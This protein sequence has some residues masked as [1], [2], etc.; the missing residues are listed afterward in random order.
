MLYDV[1]SLKKKIL[2]LYDSGEF[3]YSF[4]EDDSL[5][6]LSIKLKTPSQKSLITNIA[7][8]FDEIKKLES[9]ELHIE[10]REFSFKSLG[11]QK[12]PISVAIESEEIF[13]KFLGKRREFD[14]YKSAYLYALSKFSSL[15]NL[16]L[17][18]PN[19]LLQNQD[20][21][22]E[23]LLIC[24]F[25]MKN[26]RP[27]IYIRELSIKGVDT[28]FIQKYKGSV[29][30]FLSTVL[31]ETDFDAEV[32]KLSNSGFEKKYGLK[33][34]LPLVRFRILDEA[35]Y[36][37]GINDISLTAESFDTLNLTCKNVFIVENKI[38]MLSFMNIANS[39]VVFGNGYGVGMIKNTRWMQD[40]NI[41]YWGDIDMDGF[42]ILSQ[43]RGY[44]P[45]IESL[46]MDEE[47]LEKFR[48]LAISIEQSKMKTLVHL[49]SAESL[50]Y[51]RLQSDFYKENFRLEQERIP[52]KY[53]R[54]KMNAF[55]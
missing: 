37:N 24:Q 7:T 9:L 22:D 55:R 8:L 51:E 44:F 16:F 15:E 13:L 33:Y 52:F 5:F 49:K 12:L 46:F 31:N 35:L 23:L 1:E 19:F 32:S 30:T 40:K 11:T 6:P 4:M 43:A 20:I 28:K 34:E 18:K 10:Y 36:I 3:F 38:T 54:E 14:A 53:I 47:T 48:D 25:F 26:P 27:N 42:A 17:Q 50:L 29:D 2:K 41:Y 21:I 45:Q 39:I